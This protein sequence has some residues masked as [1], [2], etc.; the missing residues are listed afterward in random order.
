MATALI[1]CRNYSTHLE[2]ELE[3][4]LNDDGNMRS[5]TRDTCVCAR[6]NQN[7]RLAPRE[8]CSASVLGVS[9]LFQ[10]NI[11][12]SLQMQQRLANTLESESFK[13]P[14]LTHRLLISLYA[15]LPLCYL[16][17]CMNTRRACV[18][19]RAASR[20][21]KFIGAFSITWRCSIFV[22]E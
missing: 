3:S 6:R 15:R 21:C 19:L 1:S 13:K 16:S 20:G 8:S 12:L 18:R 9:S 7:R 10:S 17:L 22:L 5:G 11:F 4:F 2:A 14:H